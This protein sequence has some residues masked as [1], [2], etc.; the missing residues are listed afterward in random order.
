MKKRIILLVI[1]VVVAVIFLTPML[2]GAEI[3]QLWFTEEGKLWNATVS[4]LDFHFLEIRVQMIMGD[5]DN[6]LDV[7]FAYDEIGNMGEWFEEF[8][9][10]YTRGKI[11]IIARDTRARFSS[12][13]LKS[14]FLNYFGALTDYFKLHLLGVTNDFNNDVV[15][16]LIP[17]EGTKI[18]GLLGY[19]YKGEHVII[20]DLP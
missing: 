5:P 2:G 9:R 1:L 13:T 17:R 6:Y 14:E 20:K 18:G 3:D 11:V 10:L 15:V 16:Y 19:F 8:V 4:A 7:D 12:Y